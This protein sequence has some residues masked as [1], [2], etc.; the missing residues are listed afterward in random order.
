MEKEKRPVAGVV[1]NLQVFL[2]PLILL[3][4]KP[5]AKLQIEINLRGE[6]DDVR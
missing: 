4:E 5:D 2:Q 6:G 1:I 3:E